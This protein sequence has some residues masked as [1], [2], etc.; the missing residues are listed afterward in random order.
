MTLS[1]EQKQRGGYQSIMQ[2][3][4][5]IFL[6]NL[7]GRRGKLTEKSYEKFCHQV[8]GEVKGGRGLAL[9]RVKTSGS[10]GLGQGGAERKGASA[11]KGGRK[12]SGS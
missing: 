7:T 3:L 4:C 6:C 2:C 12:L 1:K 8:G 9:R 10:G 5:S 11:R